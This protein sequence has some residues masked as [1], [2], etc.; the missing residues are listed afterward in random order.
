MGDSCIIEV[1]KTQQ[2]ITFS[3]KGEDISGSTSI[4]HNSSVDRE[5]DSTIIDCQKSI[6]QTFALKFLTIFL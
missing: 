3:V 4:K 1:N 5:D 6:K 2:Q